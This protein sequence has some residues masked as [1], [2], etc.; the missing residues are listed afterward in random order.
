MA[1]K[2]VPSFVSTNETDTQTCSCGQ[3]DCTYDKKWG[4]K[5]GNCKR[6]RREHLATSAGYTQCP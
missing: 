2:T 6:P 3:T 4:E 1:E 5:C